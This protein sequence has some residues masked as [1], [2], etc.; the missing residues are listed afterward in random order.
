[1][2]RIDPNRIVRRYS[3]PVAAQIM[4]GVWCGASF[5]YGLYAWL[6]YSGPFR[7]L[8]DFEIEHFGS[9]Q[10]RLTAIA[11]SLMTLVLSAPLF[12]LIDRVIRRRPSLQPAPMTAVPIGK[13]P[14]TKT[15]VRAILV[16][17]LGAIV[18]AACAGVLG[19]R[20][21]Q[22][23]VTFEPLN[24]ADGIQPRSSHFEL[25]GMAVPSMQIAFTGRDI[26][27]TYMPLVPPQWHKGDPVV[28]FLSRDGDHLD[29]D[30]H[31]FQIRQQGVLIRDDLPGAVAS[32]YEKH[33]IKLGT[34]PMVL[35]TA[36][37]D[38]L[39]PYWITAA[40]GGCFGLFLL[41]PVLVIHVRERRRA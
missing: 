32:R 17:G 38:D 1:M 20:K 27:T 19:Y 33:G 8:A 28:Y 21:L 16:L 35:Y 9:Y 15:Q 18:V 39:I 4:C 23:P 6:S 3:V 22:E 5:G 30:S 37:H 13:G 7:W 25:T 12:F 29:S 41:F 36:E 34:P 11:V 26:T 2:N 31:S 14:V 10:E 40:L 24:L